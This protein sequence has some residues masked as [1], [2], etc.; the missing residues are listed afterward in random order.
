MTTASDSVV[1]GLGATPDLVLRAEN[2][3][4]GYSKVAVVHDLNLDVPK[5]Q[6]TC[7]LGA[8]GAGKSTTLRALAGALAP[9]AGKIHWLG[10]PVQSSLHV[11]ARQGLS[12][13]PEERSVIFSLSVEDNLK[14]GRGTVEAALQF[15]PE[16]KGLL[17]RK[18]GLLSGGEQQ[19]LTLA[20]ALAAEPRV[21]LADELSLGLGPMVVER[22]LA[23]VREAADRG[24]AVLL[25]EQ[26]IRSA[27]GVSD[28]GY[29]LRRGR[30]VMEGSA[31]ELA[32]RSEEIEAHY[33]T[34]VA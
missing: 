24:V 7:L 32:D 16:L 23:S 18:A 13:V 26:Y 28:R 19:I 25:V 14:L 20:R 31:T 27:L 29:V 1:T 2:L 33:L 21:L 22:L 5:G 12:Y 17:R 6:V 3:S 34:G 30:I 9:L 11:R 8:N 4:L 15:A 10:Q